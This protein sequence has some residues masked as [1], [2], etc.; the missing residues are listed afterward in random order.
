VVHLPGTRPKAPSLGNRLKTGTRRLYRDAF[1]P[2]GKVFKKAFLLIIQL[3]LVAGAIFIAYLHALPLE[4]HAPKTDYPVIDVV[5]LGCIGLIIIAILLPSISELTI[6]GASVKL[7]DATESV[8]RTSNTLDDTANLVQNWS[9]SVGI[10]AAELET[11]VNSPMEQARLMKQYYR[12]RM[13]EAKTFLTTEPADVARVVLWMYD[14]SSATIDFVWSN[15]LVPAKTSWAVGE[16]MIGKSFEEGRAFNESD[17]R[18]L[19]CYVSTRVGEPP[20]RAVLVQPVYLGDRKLGALSVDK[21]E[22]G[23]FGYVAAE[24]AKALAAQCAIAYYLWRSL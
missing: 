16:G 8:K 17:V 4:R 6:G 5:T 20:Y 7:R 12:D 3:C 9:T 13:G 15:D 22:A 24:V 10:L 19:P 11:A 1:Y 21:R 18:T 2:L 14:E 23:I